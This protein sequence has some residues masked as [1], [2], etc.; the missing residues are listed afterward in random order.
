MME[1]DRGILGGPM[2]RVVSVLILCC[3]LPAVVTPGVGASEASPTLAELVEP[4]RVLRIDGEVVRFALHWFI[5]FDSLEDLFV[6]IDGQS[7]RWEFDSARERQMFGDALLRRGVESRFV[8]IQTEL[9]R[10]LL[11][12]HTAEELA[13]AASGVATQAPGVVFSG[14]H[15]T[16]DMETYRR[17]LL[18][19]QERWKSALNCWSAS[20]SIAGR[21]LSNWYILEEGIELFGADYDSTEHF[22]Q[23][24]KYHPEVRLAD[25]E[26]L[27][28]KLRS[29]SWEPWV[30]RLAGD[31]ATYL[32]HGYAIEFLRHNLRPDRL[33]WFAA[34]VARHAP[35]VELPV[36]ELQQRVPGELRFSALEEKILWG[37]LADILHLIHFFSNSGLEGSRPPELEPVL[38]AL[39]QHGFDG[40]Y[41]EGYAGGR[42]D[43]ISA[44]FRRLMLEVFR[45]KFLGNERLLEVIR[46]TE[47]KRLL[48]FLNDGTSPDIPI[49]VYVEMLEEVRRQAL[50]D[51]GST[52]GDPSQ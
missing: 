1:R 32:E 43:F 50:E 44:E 38:E 51:A 29:V 46:S 36:R 14:E 13:T 37:D 31:Q 45:V 12:T 24:V 7:G 4:A 25:L 27:L 41:L 47:G 17:A 22:W 19:V 35:G 52:Y 30:E 28:G 3:C 26:E 20:P 23:A 40:I 42:V 16:L 48:H 18:E 15:W 49:P 33:D 6:H 10:E 11:V 9:P 5:E 8:S 2:R 34:E 39:S 21:V